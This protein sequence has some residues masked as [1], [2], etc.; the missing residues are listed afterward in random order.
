MNEVAT[1]ISGELALRSDC[2]RERLY[3]IILNINT[4]LHYSMSTV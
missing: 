2:A 1:G 4:H 3:S